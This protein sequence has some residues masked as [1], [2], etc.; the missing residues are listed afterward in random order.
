MPRRALSTLAAVAALAA[1]AAVAPGSARAADPFT[2]V[3]GLSWSLVQT[4]PSSYSVFS[5]GSC[6]GGETAALFGAVHGAVGCTGGTLEGT[7]RL[8]RGDVAVPVSLH[9]RFLPGE[10]VLGLG[11]SGGGNALAV[12]P[13]GPC[14]STPASAHGRFTLLALGL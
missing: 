13:F 9:M 14:S 3:C 10:V 6:A 5:G 2:G 8:E 12:D 4:G 11:R 1:S 7:G